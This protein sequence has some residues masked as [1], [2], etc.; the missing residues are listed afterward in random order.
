MESEE[1]EGLQRRLQCSSGDSRIPAPTIHLTH[2]ALTPIPGDLMPLLASV[3]T[4]HAHGRQTVMEAKH[5]Y[6]ENR[7][8]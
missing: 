8:K 1:W 2:N 5:S 6:V 7:N 4:R 3:D